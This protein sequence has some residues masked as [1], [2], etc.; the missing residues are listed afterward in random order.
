MKKILA[1]VLLIA[2]SV[3]S[4]QTIE[5]SGDKDYKPYSYLDGTDSKRCVC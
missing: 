1:G 4:A 5:L 2:G 3:F